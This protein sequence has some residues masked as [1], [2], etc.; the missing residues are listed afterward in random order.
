[1]ASQQKTFSFPQGL[2]IPLFLRDV[3][4]GGMV[5]SH[6]ADHHTEICQQFECKVQIWCQN[7]QKNPSNFLIQHENNPNKLRIFSNNV[8]GHGFWDGNPKS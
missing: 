3:C 6:A 8:V 7:H 5:T 2:L 1:M 4:E